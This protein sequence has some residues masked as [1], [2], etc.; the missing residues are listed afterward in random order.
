[1]C[2][3]WYDTVFR[4]AIKNRLHTDS[5]LTFSDCTPYF[6]TPP[7]PHSYPPYPSPPFSFPPPPPCSH[8]AHF[9]HQNPPLYSPP[10]LIPVLYC[11]KLSC[12][13]PRCH[14]ACKMHLSSHYFATMYCSNLLTSSPIYPPFNKMYQEKLYKKKCQN[15]E[16]CLWHFASLLHCTELYY[17]LLQC[18]VL[19]CTVL[20]WTSLYFTVLHCD[21]L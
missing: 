16:N 17:T 4:V 21:T 15:I 10:P 18:I 9:I 12:S 20:H 7:Y 1:M 8:H 19:N 13:S 2:C 5:P 11:T 3:N 14:Q 6:C